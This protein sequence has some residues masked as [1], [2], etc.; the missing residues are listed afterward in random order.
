MVGRVGAAAF[1]FMGTSPAL[2]GQAPSED[3]TVRVISSTG[4]GGE[5]EVSGRLDVPIGRVWTLLNDKLSYP[6]IF[7]EIRRMTFVRRGERGPVWRADVALPWPLGDRW[8]ED[9]S[10]AHPRTRLVR[11]WRVA[12]SIRENTGSWRLRQ[13]HSGE[14]LVTYRNRFDPGEAILPDWLVT[15]AVAVGVPKVIRNLR[16][17]LEHER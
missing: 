12:G 11:W 6:R 16:R 15:W 14:T 2:P 17:H 4:S 5:V 7:P 10:E 8:S 1:L 13:L 9:E 3:V